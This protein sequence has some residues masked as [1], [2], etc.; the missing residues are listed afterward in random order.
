MALLGLKRTSYYLP[1]RPQVFV[2]FAVAADDDDQ[3]TI[4]TTTAMKLLAA[5]A[6]TNVALVDQRVFI[7]CASFLLS[8]ATAVLVA[9]GAFVVILP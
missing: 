1:R 2:I 4:T 3:R 6:A 5:D 9:V 7:S 8:F